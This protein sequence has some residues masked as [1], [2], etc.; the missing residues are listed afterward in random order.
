MLAGDIADGQG[1]VCRCV[2][3]VEI[4]EHV[5]RVRRVAV[6]PVGLAVHGP[7]LRLQAC[8]GALKAPVPHEDEKVRRL[9]ICAYCTFFNGHFTGIHYLDVN[10]ACLTNYALGQRF[11]ETDLL[12]PVPVNVDAYRQLGPVR[13]N[14]HNLSAD[15][16][17]A[18]HCGAV[19]A[20]ITALCQYV[21][22]LH[23]VQALGAL[24]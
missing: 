13:E 10:V 7:R 8:E 19:V 5:I 18:G 17:L 16:E 1:T 21:G 2:E 3:G 4:K 6:F 23:G 9:Q 22:H 11:K 14:V 24:Y 12:N 20:E 15:C